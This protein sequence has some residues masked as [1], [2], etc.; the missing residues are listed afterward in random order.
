MLVCHEPFEEEEI[1]FIIQWIET[2]QITQ[3]DTTSWKDL[4]HVFECRFG[5]LRSDNKLKNFWNSRIR[6]IARNQTTSTASN[7]TTLS[8]RMVPLIH[9]LP[10]FE[11]KP[12]PPQFNIP[13]KMNPIF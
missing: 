12:D 10:T 13:D 7:P 11:P 5:K 2:N 6:R 4:I 3:N 9:N 8:S 1:I